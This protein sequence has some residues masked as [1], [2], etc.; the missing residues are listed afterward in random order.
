MKSHCKT[1]IT[2]KDKHKKEDSGAIIKSLSEA[3]ILQAIEDSW[4]DE[5]RERCITFFTGEEFNIC[6]GMAVM[7]H[8]DKLKVLNLFLDIVR[9]SS[10]TE[11]RIS[12]TLGKAIKKEAV[13]DHAVNTTGVAS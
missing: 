4:I 11:V 7:N 5:E 9:Q 10:E 12:N 2:V 13:N 6:A 3:K 1:K 8:D